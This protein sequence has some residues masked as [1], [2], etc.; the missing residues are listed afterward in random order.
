MTMK[1]FGKAIDVTVNKYYVVE[2]VG[3]QQYRVT[4]DF[5]SIEEAKSAKRRMP[6]GYFKVVEKVA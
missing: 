6:I 3:T 1:L 2:V 5:D 4:R